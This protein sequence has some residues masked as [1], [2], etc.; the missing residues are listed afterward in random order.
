MLKY[1]PK[2]QSQYVCETAYD[3]KK[4]QISFHLKFE[5]KL[6]ILML[7]FGKQVRINIY[8]LLGINVFIYV[9][10]MKTNGIVVPCR[11]R[12]RVIW[13]I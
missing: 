12:T 7:F 11:T 6:Q 10:S 2:I 1:M 13:V 8:S 3:G 9:N 5:H 4:M